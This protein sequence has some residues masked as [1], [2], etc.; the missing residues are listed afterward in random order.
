MCLS[1]LSVFPLQGLYVYLEGELRP[2]TYL[3]TLQEKV[4]VQRLSV[5]LRGNVGHSLFARRTDRWFP[6]QFSNQIRQTQ[7]GSQMVEYL[8]PVHF[9]LPHPGPEILLE[10][11]SLRPGVR[12]S[13]YVGRFVVRVD[14]GS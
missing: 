4:L 5:R 6:L 11:W 7:E 9:T 12:G 14:W 2:R 8:W 3:G 13:Y 10:D 1:R